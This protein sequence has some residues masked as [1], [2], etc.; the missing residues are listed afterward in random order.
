MPKSCGMRA[1]HNSL[2]ANILGSALTPS[3]QTS[4]RTLPTT[5]PTRHSMHRSGGVSR[6]HQ[7]VITT[8]VFHCLL[9]LFQ[10][11]LGSFFDGVGGPSCA[12]AL[13]ID[14]VLVC[15][16]EVLIEVTFALFC[17]V[18]RLAH[19]IFDR[20][21]HKFCNFLCV[22]FTVNA[23]TT[24]QETERSRCEDEEGSNLRVHDRLRLLGC[25]RTTSSL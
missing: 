11:F 10:I 6:S 25:N 1:A 14:L 3:L 23:A 22:L 5:W 13:G 7:A 17:F 18:P 8:V 24:T 19:A 9:K 16:N 21:C 15:G 20:V 4:R 2:K 12:V